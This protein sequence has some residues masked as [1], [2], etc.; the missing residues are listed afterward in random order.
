MKKDMFKIKRRINFLAEHQVNAFSP[1]I[2]PAPKSNERNEIESIYEGLKYYF[3]AG[4][5]D[6]IV[7]KKY[8]GSYCDI[9]LCKEI[10][11]SYFVSRNGYKISHLD[12]EALIQALKP[13]HDRMNWDN[14]AMYIIQSEMMPW[15]AL[16]GSL[17][18]NEFEAYL[19]AHD[20]HYQYL[21]ESNIYDKTSR[22][23][24]SEA[25]QNVVSDMQEM[26]KK[27][28]GKKYPQHII[29]QYKA[30]N[31]LQ[32]LDM[33]QYKKGI[34][35][36]RE[37]VAHYGRKVDLHFKPFNI[38][39]EIKTDGSEYIPN[40]NHTY[41]QVN[42]DECKTFSIKSESNLEEIYQ[43]LKKWFDELS[44]E[45]EEGI[46]IKPRVAFIPGVAPALKVRNDH[47]LTLIYGVK[48]LSDYPRNLRRRNIGRKLKCS[49][50]DWEINRKLLDIKYK[51][52]HQENYYYKNL[53]LDRIEGEAKEM[54]LDHR[55]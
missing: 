28:L 15:S 19:D 25:Y 27:A 55:L 32:V 52:I 12:H 16:G 13:I 33:A 43:E 26:D 14:H 18:E 17:I 49:I 2:S 36:Y 7:Q 44:S 41:K 6:I 24:Q 21:S 35:L 34:D 3:D 50:Y 39:K 38:L 23:K 22:I 29:R 10:S 45:M 8:M 42:N 9:Y 5:K 1:T 20:T 30:A 48:F 46:M 31:A 54:T 37:Q 40:D 47:Y 51:D 11:E 4:V 53:M